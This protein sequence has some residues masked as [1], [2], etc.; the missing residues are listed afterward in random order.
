[1]QNLADHCIVIGERMILHAVKDGEDIVQSG[2]CILTVLFGCNVFRQF[3]FK[4][5]FLCH[6][7]RNAGIGEKL[8]LIFGGHAVQQVFEFLREG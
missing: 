7:I 8:L 1:M 2:R 5:A 3:L 6:Q 4:L